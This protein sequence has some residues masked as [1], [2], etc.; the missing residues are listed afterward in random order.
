MLR[1][2]RTDVLGPWSRSSRIRLRQSGKLIAA[3]CNVTTVS[4]QERVRRLAVWQDN[5]NERD[6]RLLPPEA[7]DHPGADIGRSA[8]R[9]VLAVSSAGPDPPGLADLPPAVRRQRRQAGRLRL[10]AV[11]GRAGLRSGLPAANRLP[12][13]VVHRCGP[14][15][16]RPGPGIPRSAGPGG[17][18]LAG[19]R[20]PV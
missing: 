7:R 17:A 18:A 12:R 13:A 1:L 4:Q 19:G 15:L 6:A 2:S 11:G 14:G 9:S 10:L 16:Q 5:V 20:R 3:R 8:T